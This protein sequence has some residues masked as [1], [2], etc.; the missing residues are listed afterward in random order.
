MTIGEAR[1]LGEHRN[2][3]DGLIYGFIA[4]LWWGFMPW[5][6]SYLRNFPPFELLLHRIIW[7]VFW[8]GL[9]ITARRKVPA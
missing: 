7:S 1:D 3:R 8:V 5:Y 2:S 6:F 9:L 4:Y